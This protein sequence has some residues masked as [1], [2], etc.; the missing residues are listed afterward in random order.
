MF[1]VHEAFRAQ[2]LGYKTFALKF[3]FSRASSFTTGA[4]GARQPCSLGFGV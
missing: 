1:D 2:C 4:G 3:R